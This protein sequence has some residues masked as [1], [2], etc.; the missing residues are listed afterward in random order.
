MRI[1]DRVER[2]SPSLTLQLVARTKELKAAG[3]DVISLGAGEPDFPTP[4]NIRRAA[5]RA[6]EL[7]HTRYTDVAGIPALRTAVADLYRAEHGLEYA[8]TDVLVCP[9]AKFALFLALQALVDAGDRVLVPQ[10]SWLSYPEMVKAAGG[11]PVSVPTHE[12]RGFRL[13]A[14]D[15]EA[16]LAD[17]G[18]KVLIL[19]TVSNPTGGVHTA[20]DCAAIA[21]LCHRHG[22][23]VISDEIYERLVYE[24]AVASSFAASSPVAKELTLVVSGVSKTFAM[25]GW[26]IG[27]AAGPSK[28]IAA[29]KKL[30]G[31]ATSN[32]CSIA[33]YAALEA[34]TGDQSTVETMRVEF[35]RRRDRLVEL[36]RAIPG[37]DVAEPQGAFYAFPR[38]DEYYGR[39]ADVTDS[40]SF[41]GALLEEAN[42]VVVPG[43]PFG[44]DAHVRLS[45]AC[46]MQDIETAV[47]RMSDWM[48]GL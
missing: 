22:V 38:V 45:Y 35:R 12:E 29:M 42:V 34:I 33:Q 20:E 24:P 2:L 43:L 32:P 13:D 28:L 5:A 30:Q 18:A 41:A 48:Q 6:I 14:A 26:R 10:P 9:G 11:T 3:R 23:T 1:S 7:G 16:A 8:P 15:V 46:S 27:Y 47:G 36:L 19:N 44:S 17:G 25:T 40:L 4:E 39:R 37:V 21:Q 31:Q